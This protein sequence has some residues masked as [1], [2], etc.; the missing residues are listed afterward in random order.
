MRS[1]PSAEAIG[2][3]LFLASGATVAGPG[4]LAY[5]AVLADGAAPHAVPGRVSAHQPVAGS[6]QTFAT[7]SSPVFGFDGWNYWFNW[8]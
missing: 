7:S 5:A 3:G 1:S 4:R 6:L 2:T 8:A